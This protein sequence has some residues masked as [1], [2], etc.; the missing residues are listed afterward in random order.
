MYCNFVENISM[1]MIIKVYNK[2][3]IIFNII[4]LSMF[5]CCFRGEEIMWLLLGKVNIDI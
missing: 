3:V 5:V 1:W 2:F 4:G